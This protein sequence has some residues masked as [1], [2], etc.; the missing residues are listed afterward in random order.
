MKVS[1]AMHSVVAMA[2][3][4]NP[5][6]PSFYFRELKGTEIQELPDNIFAE[7]VELMDL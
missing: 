2:M 4:A 1:V 7:N 5:D 3:T 6:Q